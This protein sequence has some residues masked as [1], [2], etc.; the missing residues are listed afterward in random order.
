[1]FGRG[2]GANLTGQAIVLG[3]EIVAL[4]LVG[5][6]L[7]GTQWRKMR[8]APA[9]QAPAHGAA[10]P[11]RVP[12]PVLGV[13]TALW[14]SALPAL[15]RRHRRGHR[16]R[17]ADRQSPYVVACLVVASGSLL[18]ALALGR[19]RATP[20]R[21]RPPATQVPGSQSNRCESM[22]E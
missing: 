15:F 8:S 19:D 1:M 14:I 21:P 6:Y 22:G 4:W 7:L 11:A 2:E 16:R 17:H 18:A 10:V 20:G 5:L 9:A 3:I 12:V 13:H